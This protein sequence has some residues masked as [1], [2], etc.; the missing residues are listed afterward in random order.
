MTRKVF[1]SLP[2]LLSNKRICWIIL[3]KLKPSGMNEYYH[4]PIDVVFEG[5]Y[6]NF[7]MKDFRIWKDPIGQP[8]TSKRYDNYKVSIH[9]KDIQSI[10]FYIP[11]FRKIMGI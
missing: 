6:I 10:D 4:Y 5:E 1:K 3:H 9:R 11:I 7:V 2:R 8:N